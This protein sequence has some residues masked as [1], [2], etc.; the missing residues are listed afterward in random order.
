M[1]VLLKSKENVTPENERP[2]QSLE[3]LDHEHLC[4]IAFL[5]QE[6]HKLFKGFCE[7]LEGRGID[8]QFK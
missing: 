2:D 8:D 3:L 1:L 7:F 6:L 4:R 5:S